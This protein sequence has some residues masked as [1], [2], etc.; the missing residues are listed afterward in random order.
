MDENRRRQRPYFIW[1]YDLTEAEVRAILRSEDP[2]EKAWLITRILEAAHFEDI[3]NYLTIQDI[4][5]NFPYLRF[6]FRD[7]RDLWAMALEL[8]S[9]P[10]EQARVREEPAGYAIERTPQLMPGIL[11]PLQFEVLRRFFAG[12][13]SKQ[14]FLT[15]GTALAAF[16]LHHRLSD[17]LDLFTLDKA[18]LD[19]G[20]ETAV[21]IG[22]EL[23]YPA[24]VTINEFW[25]KRIDIRP[26]E[27]PPL[28]IDMVRDI[29]I[30]FGTHQVCEGIIVDSML[31]IAVNKITAIFGR[32]AMKDLIDLYF[33]LQMGYSLPALF[34][35]AKEKDR[36]FTLFYFAG[37][38]RHAIKPGPLPVMLKPLN[39]DEMLEF[40]RQLVDRLLRE[41]KPEV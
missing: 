13:V 21:Q 18:M 15:G 12:D 22:A 34:E 4:R 24:T 17:D 20:A 7:I 37:M 8:W 10:E 16:Y 5:D 32:A 2:Y 36:G 39:V 1:D 35:L 6:R 26:P 11:T 33:L 38:L 30:Q 3:W 28:K 23:N 9:R 27:A 29:D 19:L 41:T 14:F 40:Y 31:N 25:Y